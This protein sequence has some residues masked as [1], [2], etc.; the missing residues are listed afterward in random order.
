MTTTTARK[1]DRLIVW[2]GGTII[3]AAMLRK[4]DVVEVVR[5]KGGKG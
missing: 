5:A 2:R 4:G 1:H 3:H